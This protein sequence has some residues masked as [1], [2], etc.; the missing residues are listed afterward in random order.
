MFGGKT[1]VFEWSGK[2]RKERLAPF[3]SKMKSLLRKYVDIRG[4][5]V[6]TDHLFV[7]VDNEPLSKR[8]IQE[9]LHDYGV[10]AGM[11]GVRVSPHTFRHTFAKMYIKNGGDAFTLQA[12][13]GHSTLEMVR[14]Y[15]NMFSSDVVENRFNSTLVGEYFPEVWSLGGRGT[16]SWTMYRSGFLRGG[17]TLSV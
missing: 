6:V 3:Q 9:R 5:I 7:T 14:H 12:I 11:A 17:N 4:N 1:A 8:N 15:I 16:S 10:S 2:G 13:L